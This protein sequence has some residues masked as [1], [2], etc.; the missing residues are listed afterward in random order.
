MKIRLNESP[1]RSFWAREL[2]RGLGSLVVGVTV[3]M[4]GPT[5]LVPLMPGGSGAAVGVSVLAGVLAYLALSRG[6]DV[7]KLSGWWALA[8]WLAFTSILTVLVDLA[9]R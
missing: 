8:F 3:A 6:R 9:W 5:V 7:L 4:V 1:P 2:E